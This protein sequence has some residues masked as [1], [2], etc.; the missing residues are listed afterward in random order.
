MRPSI[1]K[2]DLVIIEKNKKLKE[3]Q[4]IAY[5]NEGLIVVHRLTSVLIYNNETFYYTKGD[6]NDSIDNLVLTE[7]KIIGVVNVV[8][9][10]IGLPAVWI[11]DL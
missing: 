7:D 3:G 2:G 9:P 10:Y 1:N 6:A 8:I 5:D 11:K 4:V